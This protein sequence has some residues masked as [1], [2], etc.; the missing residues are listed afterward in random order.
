M[1]KINYLE[2]ENKKLKD[3]IKCDQYPDGGIV[4]AIDYS[5]DTVEMYRIGKTGDLNKRKSIYNS[6]TLHKKNVIHIIETDCP[7][8]LESC[9]RSLLYKYRYQ[10]KR[11]FYECNLAK[12]KK[13]FKTCIDSIDCMEQIGGGNIFTNEIILLKNKISKL[14]GK[15]NKINKYF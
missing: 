15:I 10:N 4:Y 13:A 6:H 2:K 12:I 14:K 8:R 7:L 5:D 9:V 1:K 3:D 11:D